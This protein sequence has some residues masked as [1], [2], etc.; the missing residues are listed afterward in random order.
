MVAILCEQ[1][2]K[3]QGIFVEIAA[4]LVQKPR[5]QCCPTP[6]EVSSTALVPPGCVRKFDFNRRGTILN[7]YYL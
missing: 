5:L 3:E 2:D 1:T 7:V 4:I 6:V